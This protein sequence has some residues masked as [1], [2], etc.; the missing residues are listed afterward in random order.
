MV[1]VIGYLSQGVFL[2]F[3][4]LLSVMLLGLICV[5]TLAYIDAIK[6]EYC[7]RRKKRKKHKEYKKRDL[8]L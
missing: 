5:F 3:L 1:E 6:N 4:V 2:L 8:W 7:K